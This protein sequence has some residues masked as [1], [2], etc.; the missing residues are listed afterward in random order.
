MA[1][2]W[3]EE[4]D[5]WVVTSP[6]EY[7][8]E[9]E[10]Q[11]LIELNP[12]LLTL[13]GSPSLTML[14]REVNVANCSI[15]ILAVEST[16]RPVI[17]EAKLLSNS[18]ARRRVVAQVLEYGAVLRGLD[19]PTLEQRVRLST[20]SGQGHDSIYDAVVSNH[21]TLPTE[22]ESF[23]ST[24]QGHLARGDFRL[25]LV[26]DDAPI[27]LQRIVYY[28]DEITTDEV[29]VDLVTVRMY[30]VNGVRTVMTERMIPDPEQFAI[31]VGPPNSGSSTVRT[32]GSGAFRISTSDATDSARDMF[33]RLIEWAESLSELPH[34]RLRSGV[35]VDNTSLSP[36]VARQNAGLVTIFS[37]R[38][39]PGLQLNW[40][41]ISRCAPNLVGEIRE[42]AGE[43]EAPYTSYTHDPP[44]QLL[45]ALANAYREAENAP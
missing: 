28:L 6:Q 40:T 12:Q 13:S 7:G 23:Y 43:P 45:D 37:D 44:P 10:L 21:P 34:V 11:K 38:G 8:D 20:L 17:I 39:R 32:E 4:E 30:G 36:R 19:L 29:T 26:L 2:L 3:T 9:E 22:E 24:L 27:E 33:D 35:G 31:S 14:G 41:V 15:D 25:V 18:E 42:I 1:E 5:N 16:G